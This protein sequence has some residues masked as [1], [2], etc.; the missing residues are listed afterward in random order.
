VN[1]RQLRGTLGGRTAP[2]SSE[3]GPE[4]SGVQSP[5]DRWPPFECFCLFFRGRASRARVPVCRH[6]SSSSSH[7][8][9]SA[10]HARVGLC[11]SLHAR[12]S[13]VRPAGTRFETAPFPPE[14]LGEIGL[15]VA[16]FVIP[17]AAQRAAIPEGRTRGQ[18]QPEHGDY[19]RGRGVT[20]RAVRPACLLDPPG[21]SRCSLPPGQALEWNIVV[22]H[23][24]IRKVAEI[25]GPRTFC[26]ATELEPTSGS[27]FLAGSQSSTSLA[28]SN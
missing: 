28:T 11:A 9:S 19:A 5:L 26:R 17:P 18:R 14:R 7:V 6:L 3:P 8:A 10:G 1:P 22:Q 25:A 24:E 16:S 21:E 2:A 20:D 12:T 13:L 27:S 23:R 4:P 15:R